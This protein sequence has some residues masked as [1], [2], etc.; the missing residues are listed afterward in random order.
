[1]PHH[2]MCM[3]RKGA[4]RATNACTCDVLTWEVGSGA[5]NDVSSYKSPCRPG[6][7]YPADPICGAQVVREGRPCHLYFDLEFVPAC[8]PATD[9]DMMVTLLLD[10]VRRGLRCEAAS[11]FQ[12]S[13]LGFV[14]VSGK[15][16]TMRHILCPNNRPN[17]HVEARG[18]ACQCGNHCAECQ[19]VQGCRI[20]PV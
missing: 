14:E 5:L 19:V 3:L 1:M 9:G 16:S 17:K 13:G 7:K 11:H 12:V 18:R 10:L 20:V 6:S 15:G 8:N 4:S 2:P